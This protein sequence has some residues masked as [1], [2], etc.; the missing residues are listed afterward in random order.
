MSD[1]DKKKAAHRALV[2]RVLSGK[3]S[4]SPDERVCA[5]HN[6]D[7]PLP[8]RALIDKVATNPTQ[9]TDADFA[10][11]KA[12]GFSENQL[13]EL[14]VSAAVGRSARLYDAGLATLAEATGGEAT[15]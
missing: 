11:A 6:A 14:V 9:V 10:S 8:L 7:V 12:A 5:F 15:E 1:E 2:E 13:F 4:A 3:G